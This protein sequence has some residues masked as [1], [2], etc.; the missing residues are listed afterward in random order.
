MLPFAGSPLD[1]QVRA[2]LTPQVGLFIAGTAE[3]FTPF[4]AAF[5]RTVERCSNPDAPDLNTLAQQL[6]APAPIVAE[7]LRHVIFAL[8]TA[9]E[10]SRLETA[11]HKTLYS[12]MR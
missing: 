7:A 12:P 1:M 2:L 6:G 8:L 10:A 4:V 11:Y 3:E 9:A 5:A